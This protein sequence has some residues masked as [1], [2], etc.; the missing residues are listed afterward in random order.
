MRL[1]DLGRIEVVDVNQ[2]LFLPQELIDIPAQVIEVY[3]CRIKPRDNDMD[4]SQEVLKRHVHVH[5]TPV[6]VSMAI[7]SLTSPV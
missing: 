4:W 6:F 5:V 2:L 3:L 1:I 7:C